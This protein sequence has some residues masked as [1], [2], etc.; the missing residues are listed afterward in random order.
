[1]SLQGLS[2]TSAAREPLSNLTSLQ[3]AVL[4]HQTCRHPRLDRARHHAYVSRNNRKKRLPTEQFPSAISQRTDLFPGYPAILL[5]PPPRLGRVEESFLACAPR[6]E[7][8]TLRKC[9]TGG[10]WGNKRAQMG[11]C[12]PRSTF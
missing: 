7:N 9:G 11:Y 1:V 5:T 8:G 4:D 3:K 12:T 2:G 6:R 10:W